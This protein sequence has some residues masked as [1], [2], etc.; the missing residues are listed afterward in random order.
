MWDS[1]SQGNTMKAVRTFLPFL[2]STAAGIAI[3]AWLVTI[4][5]SDTISFLLLFF[6]GWAAPYRV[7]EFLE[8]WKGMQTIE[9]KKNPN[10]E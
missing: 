1:V 9:A 3:V 4:A 5:P 10:E 7:Q 8:L 6:L 2:L